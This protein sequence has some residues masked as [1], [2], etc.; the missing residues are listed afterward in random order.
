[1]YKTCTTPCIHVGL[2]RVYLFSMHLMH[3]DAL[4]A[5]T[6]PWPSPQPGLCGAPGNLRSRGCQALE[7]ISAPL[8][9]LG[10]CPLGRVHRAA[11]SLASTSTGVV[12]GARQLAQP[13]LS[14]FAARPSPAAAVGSLPA[15][16]CPS[17]S[18]SLAFTT[19]GV[20]WGARQLAQ[21]W[22]SSFAAHQCPSCSCWVAARVDVSIGQ[23]CPWPS[24][25]PGLCGAPGS[26]RSRGCQAY[27]FYEAGD[28]Q[29]PRGGLGNMSQQLLLMANLSPSLRYVVPAVS[30]ENQFSGHSCSMCWHL[31][32]CPSCSCPPACRTG[33]CHKFATLQQLLAGGASWSQQ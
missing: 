7:H 32:L 9:L 4:G 28:G 33:S 8:Q 24:P 22:L 16:T 18:L 31:L 2:A 12:W 19:T 29:P 11:L 21:P 30:C 6:H 23:P 17:G 20:V 1:M 25:Q 5:C 3:A 27:A 15:W 10:R 13:W 14:S 26:L